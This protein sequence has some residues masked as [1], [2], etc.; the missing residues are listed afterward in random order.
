M[1]R[2]SCSSESWLLACEEQVGAVCLDIISNQGSEEEH[3]MP[4]LEPTRI[5]V[6]VPAYQGLQTAKKVWNGR[7]LMQ[8]VSVGL[9][10]GVCCPS[11][12]ISWINLHAS[13]VAAAVLARLHRAE[14]AHE[15]TGRLRGQNLRNS[16]GTEARQPGEGRAVLLVAGWP[17]RMIARLPE[18][19][20]RALGANSA[21]EGPKGH[22]LALE[23]VKRKAQKLSA[24][25]KVKRHKLRASRTAL[26]AE[27]PRE[28]YNPVRSM[29]PVWG[30]AEDFMMGAGSLAVSTARGAAQGAVVAAKGAVKDTVKSYNEVMKEL[31]RAAAA[32]STYSE[33]ENGDEDDLIESEGL[34][35]GRRM[36]NLQNDPSDLGLALLPGWPTAD[37]RCLSQRAVCAVIELPLL[38]ASVAKADNPRLDMDEREE[39]REDREE[40]HEE[41]TRS[42]TSSFFDTGSPSSSAAGSTAGSK[43]ASPVLTYATPAPARQGTEFLLGEL[44]E[45]AKKSLLRMNTSASQFVEETQRTVGK[46]WQVAQS[47]ATEFAEKAVS[48]VKNL[49]RHR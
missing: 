2:S 28:R 3:V 15:K 21:P 46:S 17:N 36:Q 38:P 37:L 12:S 9:S 23:E 14:L 1:Q 42:V 33:Q 8:A 30:K 26:M 29:L 20:A 5:H 22:A 32:G 11:I 47:Y 10:G 4:L 18:G 31:K 39:E 45:T 7:E 19:S 49:A 34:T 43:P 48:K 44:P 40:A 35:S 13:D 16:L 27:M 6:G 24:R 41:V 25:S